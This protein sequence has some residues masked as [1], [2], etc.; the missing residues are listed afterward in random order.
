MKITVVKHARGLVACANNSSARKPSVERD[1]RKYPP[2]CLHLK[3]DRS[4]EGSCAATDQYR[5][6][7]PSEHLLDFSNS[8]SYTILTT[9]LP[10]PSSLP[11]HHEPPVRPAKSPDRSALACISLHPIVRHRHLTLPLEVKV[12]PSCPNLR[13]AAPPSPHCLPR[14]CALSCAAL[15]QHH[16]DISAAYPIRVCDRPASQ[17]AHHGVDHRSAEPRLTTPA[18]LRRS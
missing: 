1:L 17:P 8:T 9:A 14:H 12:Y 10:P 11:T 6:D 2:T 5:T 7:C 16:Y 15:H 4:G 18:S 13:A 3:S